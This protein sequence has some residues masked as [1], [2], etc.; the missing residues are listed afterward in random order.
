[1]GPPVL[2]QRARSGA[3]KV[4]QSHVMQVAIE[5]ASKGRVKVGVTRVPPS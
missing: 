5:E 1:M 3:A 4:R 2:S